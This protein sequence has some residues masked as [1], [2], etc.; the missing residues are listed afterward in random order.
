MIVCVMIEAREDHTEPLFCSD[1]EGWED[2]HRIPKWF[3]LV[4]PPQTMVASFIAPHSTCKEDCLTIGE[5]PF[6]RCII[7]ARQGEA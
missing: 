5:V 1:D 6:S 3:S 2:D 4:R 7:S